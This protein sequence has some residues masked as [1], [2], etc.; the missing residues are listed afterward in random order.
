[1]KKFY[2]VLIWGIALLSGCENLEDTYDRFSEE[3]LIRYVGK[4]SDLKLS[5]GWERMVL[6]WKNNIDSSIDKIKITWTNELETHDTLIDKALETCNIT[7]LVDAAYT[8]EV[9][10]VDKHGN[11][12]FSEIGYGRPYTQMHEEVL[13]FSKVISKH[14]KVGQ[15]NVVLFFDAWQNTLKDVYMTYFQD[16]QEQHLTLTKEIVGKRYLVLE[17]IDLTEDIMLYRT[18]TLEECPDLIQFDPITLD[19]KDRTFTND[20]SQM[21]RNRY[22]IE[23]IDDDFVNSITELEL[24]YDLKSLEDIFYFSSLE[25][26]SLGKNRYLDGNYLEEGLEDK[27]SS[28]DEVEKSLYVLDQVFK[29]AGVMVD[30]YNDNYFSAEE[31]AGRTYIREMG[32][33]NLP[34]LNYLNTEGWTI[35]PTEK[36]ES[37][38]DAHCEHLLDNNSATIW[39][40]RM[41]TTKVRTHELTIDMK[42][43]KTFNGIKIVQKAFQ[44]FWDGDNYYLPSMIKIQVSS[45]NVTWSIPMISD[46]NKI[47]NTPG[48]VTI[49]RMKE[50]IAARYIRVMVNDVINYGQYN[51]LLAD[52]AVFE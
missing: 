4:C 29:L 27:I 25:K 11:T 51:T 18:G 34:D 15:S 46:E 50:P 52:I 5:P 1:M 32:N 16:E 3:G 23:N 39:K 45:D 2:I 10:A 44:Y 38:Y 7:N 28:L 12:S 20:F 40:P 30:I 49:L 37:G 36:D 26:V 9:C 33:P 24:D 43:K 41:S 8:F 42:E 19:F 13:S 48:E 14:F 17:G 31:I 47:G 6:K 21:L 35:T 22:Q